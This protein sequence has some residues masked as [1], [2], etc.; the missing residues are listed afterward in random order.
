MERE[1]HRDVEHHVM[2]SFIIVLGLALLPIEAAAQVVRMPV[3]S[4]WTAWAGET[5]H[6]FAAS[7][8]Q[9]N[10][11]GNLTAISGQRVAIGPIKFLQPSVSVTFK[12]PAASSAAGFKIVAIRVHH[13]AACLNMTMAERPL[14]HL[15]PTPLL[16]PPGQPFS[17]RY[18][19]PLV[20]Y[21]ELIC[22]V[23]PASALPGATA[24]APTPTPTPTPIPTPTPTTAT[25]AIAPSGSLV[26]PQG[27]WTFGTATA[28]GG[29]ALLL[30]GIN[31]G[32]GFG[33]KLVFTTA[34]VL[35]T[36]TL[37]G[38]WF[39]WTGTGWTQSAAPQ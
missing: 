38:R 15:L 37:D 34:G 6:S 7:P 21:G 16:V 14:D 18:D 9:L 13:E 10:T 24:P 33:T 29:N 20:G 35:Y 4:P 31:T 39:S 27:T 28:A 12:G 17:C 26:T 19:M 36:F 25:T 5:K 22:G 3:C 32:G 2:R 1:R 11:L 30:N 23:G 8:L